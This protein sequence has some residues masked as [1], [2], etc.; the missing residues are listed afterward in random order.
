MY[1]VKHILT[2]L[3]KRSMQVPQHV[4]NINFK[5]FNKIEYFKTNRVNKLV[6]KL[7]LEEHSQINVLLKV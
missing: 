1:I 2:Y 6:L 3:L 5:M 7:I 4:S